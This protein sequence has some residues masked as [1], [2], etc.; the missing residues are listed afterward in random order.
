MIRTPLILTALI[1]TALGAA[2]AQTG[3][4]GQRQMTPEMQARLKA[5]QPVTDLAQTVRLL[6]DLEK[7]KATALTKAQA[8]QLL[9]I[10]T[11]LQKASSVQPND[12]KKYLTQIEDRILTGKQLA[13]LDTLL[14]KA[15]QE[16]EARRTQNQSGQNQS[17]LVPGMPSALG[18]LMGGQRPA[19]ASQAG[20]GQNSQGG[21]PGQP[22]QFNPFRQGRSAEQLGAYIKVLQKK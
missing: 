14:L 3:T 4:T 11:T 6:P 1:L 7:N 13:A 2:G 9:P 21:Q 10:L 18:G 17:Q 15:E 22:G 16:R 19:G 8:K 12:A 5:M 20:P